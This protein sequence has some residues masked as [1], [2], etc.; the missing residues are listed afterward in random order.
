VRQWKLVHL[1]N[2]DEDFTLK[3]VTRK[4]TQSGNGFR[5]LEAPSGQ[6]PVFNDVRRR[7]WSSYSK[8]HAR[9]IPRIG[10]G[11]ITHPFQFIIHDH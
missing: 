9:I 10:H 2:P 11:L 7:F 8:A 1:P 4:L 3:E 6:P 5:I